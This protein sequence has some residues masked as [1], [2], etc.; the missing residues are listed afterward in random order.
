MRLPPPGLLRIDRDALLRDV[1]AQ[2]AARLASRGLE[3][4][5]T[6]PAWI[7]LEQAAWMVEILSE[8][9]DQYPFAVL[10]QLLHLMG[11]H[12]LPARPALGAVLAQVS[13]EGE[14]RIDPALP[15]PWRLFTPQGERRDAVEFVPA[16]PAVPLWRGAAVDLVEIRDGE[17]FRAGA[18][19]V[20]G[21]DAL[22][23]WRRTPI[24]GEA[25]DGERIR[26]L[27][28]SANPAALAAALGEAVK[29]VE[30]RRIGWLRL[31]VEPAGERVALVAQIDP[32]GAFARTAP[33]GVWGGGDLLGDWGNLDES[34]WTPPV[35]LADLPSLPPRIR[36]SRPL[37]AP[38]EGRILLPDLPQ[39]VATARLL[40]RAASPV[41][42]GAVAA[43]WRTV[44][45]QDTRLRALRPSVERALGPAGGWLG[46]ALEVGL[47]P[48]LAAGGHSHVAQIKLTPGRDTLSDARVGLIFS[49][50]D[51]VV[52]PSTEIYALDAAGRPSA[53]PLPARLAW[54]LPAAAAPGQRGLSTVVAWDVAVP[55][56][57]GG[58]LLATRHAPE[59]ALLNPMLVINAPVVRDGRR[60]TVQR[61]VPETLSL[62]FEDVVSPEVRRQLVEQPLAPVT[63]ALLAALPLARF[64]VHDGEPLADLAGL[65]TDPTEGTV[66]LNAPAGD[67]GLPPLRP[68]A[69]L[70]LDWYRRT[71]GAA[72]GVAAGAISL[73]EQEPTVRPFLLKVSNPL[74]TLFGADRESP[75][76]AMDRLSVP[77]SGLPVLPADFERLARQALGSR[78][79]GWMVR[80]WTYAERALLS[81]A[82]WPPEG[83]RADLGRPL[84]PETRALRAAL[85]TAGP[86]V[87]LFV[88]GDPQGRLSDEDLSWARLV[89]T[90]Q[91]RLLSERLPVV[92]D[93]L[94]SRLWPLTLAPD[95]GAEAPTLPSYQP[96]AWSGLLR[97]AQGRTSRPPLAELL[98]NAAVVR[99]ERP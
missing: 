15:S 49:G 98:L 13:R 55:E 75:E 7:L 73:V 24:R 6:D 57:V 42:E 70:K 23:A 81:V 74:G 64:G 10:R 20:E 80:C 56:G 66:T 79:Q 62:L 99:L 86:D 50:A 11:G 88:V 87:L 34:G 76:A 21:T 45:S 71:D 92:R 41:P 14:L 85:E 1:A 47:W 29:K 30:E 51:P 96:D 63:A 35:R 77:A 17:L 53:T 12:L 54:V 90:R 18:G 3:P 46:P 65:A 33:G 59:A 16:E 19:G 28:M 38:E 43:I 27:A 31:S 26:Y 94:V 58:L 83:G 61:H 2:L 40:V 52:A 8:Q 39:D 82:T 5:P 97:D 48:I 69:R 89:L 78:G 32:A 4:D 37:P 84:D 91:I 67:G 22:I 25:F 93:A 9:L 68:A 44:A 72:G 95:G 60:W 36:G